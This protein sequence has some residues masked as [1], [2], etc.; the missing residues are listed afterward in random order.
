MLGMREHGDEVYGAVPALGDSSPLN[1][2]FRLAVFGKCVK[3][4]KCLPIE[5][6]FDEGKNNRA[7]HEVER[8]FLPCDL[9]SLVFCP[10]TR[11]EAQIVLAESSF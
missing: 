3:Q 7:V 6:G 2:T 5:E 4:R 1:I 9:Q 8:H 11:R 10:L